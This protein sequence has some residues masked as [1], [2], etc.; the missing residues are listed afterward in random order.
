MTS[1]HEKR[2][3][4][5]LELEQQELE[6]QQAKENKRQQKLMAQQERPVN[7]PVDCACLIH[8][9]GYDW[10]YVEKL[11][12]ML[13][14][15]LTGGVRFHV[16]TEHDRSVP[17]H[18]NKHIL[19]EWPIEAGPRSSWWYKIQLFDPAKFD[20][21]LLYL[22]LDTVI[23]RNLDWIRGLS[24]KYFWAP[25]D[26]RRLWRNNHRGINSSVMWWDTRRCSW[27]WEDFLNKE[28]MQT[29][30]KFYG[31]QEY[32]SSILDDKLRRYLPEE[33]IQSWRWEIKD[34]GM[35]FKR[36]IYLKPGQ[37]TC[38]QPNTDVLIFHGRPKPHEVRDDV[39]NQN[40][41]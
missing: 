23:A 27:I 19:D 14:R 17:P 28:M 22:D 35:D 18:M 20:G 6:R 37:G 41:C 21:N 25:K 11:Y 7:G 30:R 32:L 36:R 33:R 1:K 5:Q 40:W 39:I 16:Y 4:R 2:L 34:G 12:N 13:N 31:D 10:Q 26:F 9:K 38:L 24:T 15:S 8:G 29:T 3:Q